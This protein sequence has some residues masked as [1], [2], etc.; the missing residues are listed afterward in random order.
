MRRMD[1]LRAMQTFVAIADHG[2]LTAA[3]AALGGSLP[4]VVRQLA[5]YEASLGVRLFHRTTRRV[6]LTDEGRQ[7]LERCRAVLESVQEAE[8]ALSAGAL[9]PGGK[10]VVTAPVLFGQLYVAPSVTRFLAAQPQL[11]C[12]VLLLDRIV[13]LV[14]EGIDIAVRIGRLEDSSLVALPLGRIR[15]VVVAQ[16]AFLRRHGTPRHPRD[17]QKAPCVR[18]L[19]GA[20]G[21]GEFQ[22]NGRSFRVPVHG[23][24]EFNHVL[25]AVQACA[26]GAGFGMFFTY[27]VQPLLEARQLKIV[28]QPFELP[29]RP[30]SLVYPHAR[31]L[32]AR[33]RAFIDWIRADLGGAFTG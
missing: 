28:L 30:I 33:T 26:A 29:P 5:A 32:P 6:T 23:R 20:P 7:H 3:A 11:Q 22:E 17:L 14:E 31:L 25:P 27:Q 16:P 19:G 2:S 15:R 10:L 21:W 12:Q 1:K 9:R 4:A 13:N 8:A 18:V 24:L